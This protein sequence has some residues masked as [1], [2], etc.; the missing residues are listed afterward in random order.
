MRETREERDQRLTAGGDRGKALLSLINDFGSSVL[1]AEKIGVSSSMVGAWISSG[2]ISM[3]GATILAEKLGR[4]REEFRPDLT[5]ED[6]LR[7][8]PGP[9]PGQPAISETDDAKLLVSVAE[10]FGGT[11]ALCQALNI[12][13]PTFH[14]WKTRGKIPT[15][16]MAAVKELAEQ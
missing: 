7:A 14:C 5:A 11:A 10:K 3:R 12:T 8:F 9:I 4:T 15:R 13:I 6:W 2:K 16:R 1:I